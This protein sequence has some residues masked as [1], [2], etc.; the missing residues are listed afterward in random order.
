MFI[1][2]VKTKDNTKYII[3]ITETKNCINCYILKRKFIGYEKLYWHKSWRELIPDY[4]YVTLCTI[5]N[6]EQSL[7]DKERLIKWSMS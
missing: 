7:K 2:E 1:K 5:C 3:G 4:D 6:Y